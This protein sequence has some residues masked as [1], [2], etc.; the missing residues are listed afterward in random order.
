MAVAVDRGFFATLPTLS[1]VPVEHADVAWL[2]YELQLTDQGRYTLVHCQT[3]YTQFTTALQRI[4]N[5][6]HGLEDVFRT[7]LQ[8]KLDHKHIENTISPDALSLLESST[9]DETTEEF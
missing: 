1:H 9:P 4:T 2:V 6:E 5:A 7:I 8:R 3:V